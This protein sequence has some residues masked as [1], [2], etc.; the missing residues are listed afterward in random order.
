MHHSPYHFCSAAMAAD[1]KPGAI[2]VTVMVPLPS[3]QFRVLEV[4]AFGIVRL[5]TCSACARCQEHDARYNFGTVETLVHERIQ[6]GM[7]CANCEEACFCALPDLT[8]V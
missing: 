7:E 4:G 5:L 1:M 6:P 8:G 3:K 2:I